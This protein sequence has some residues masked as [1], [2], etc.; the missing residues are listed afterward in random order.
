MFTTIL[1]FTCV[2][3]VH[4]ED[5]YWVPKDPPKSLYTV[6]A[7]FDI[8]GGLL[9]GSEEIVFTNNT[10]RPIGVLALSWSIDDD[11]SLEISIDGEAPALLNSENGVPTS[12][13][14]FYR[15]PQHVAPG[16]KVI[17]KIKFSERWKTAADETEIVTSGW[18]Y[19]RLWWDGLPFHDSFRMKLEVPEGWTLALGGRL[20]PESGYYE[21]E[22]G[23]TCGFYLGKG[24]KT[25]S[26]EVEGVLV[27]LLFRE[28][29][30]RAAKVCFETAVD[31]IAFYKQR[32][33]FYPFRFLYFVP[34]V[35]GRPMGG[36]PV[37]T[38]IV[39]IHGFDA[40]E[41]RDLLHWQWIT[42]HEIGHQ[43]WGEWV[44]DPDNPGWLWIGMGI[45][46][47]R[48]Y[49][50]ARGLSLAR[51]EGLMKRYIDGVMERNDTTMDI[52]PAQADKIEYDWNNVTV[53]GKGFSVISA[54]DAA[55]GREAFERV[56]RRC[57]HDYGGRRLG[58]REFSRVC[59]EESGENLGW[60][61]EQWVRSCK[62]LSCK[63]ESRECAAEGGRF[64]STVVI[65]SELETIKMPVEVKAVFAD[66]SEQV[67]RT[68]RCFE[69]SI[70]RFE[71]GSPL[72]DLVIDPEKKLP[73]VINPP[74]R[75]AAEI[76]AIVGAM[77]WSGE[78]EKALE[79]YGLV[80]GTEI[81][82]ARTWLKL[83][84]LL[85]D[86]GHDAE[87]MDSLERVPALEASDLYKFAAYIW[88]GH[89]EDLAG[90]REAAIDHYRKALEFDRGDSL[91]HSNYGIIL[92][93]A[94]VE[95]RLAT[96]FTRER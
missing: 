93:R 63:V 28:T 91:Q 9:Q 73:L 95:E 11:S 19:P 39:V 23:R 27:T 30:E 89:L 83:G 75:A 16:G 57:L 72:A 82:S 66:G 76:D 77:G 8:D 3:H 12:S 87:A 15:L 31:A 68:S 94:W 64:V 20:N 79:V 84:L 49:I 41:K 55:L 69:R 92:N 67:K 34:G 47:D 90:K 44:L 33:G 2:V 80:R 88:M 18:W 96:P 59:E 21:N 61:F 48:E 4:A 13:P 22:G 71:S 52:P 60:F 24:M 70:L 25:L 81:T 6:D 53:H 26:R 36:Y 85:Y 38:G 35:P 10:A 37:A 62:F 17:L 32:F 7:R 58:W 1:F 14:L 42:A 86:G 50:N 43:F 78:E 29:E 46:A 5:E 40:F 54:L 65:R 74:S 45:F 56:Y 51:H